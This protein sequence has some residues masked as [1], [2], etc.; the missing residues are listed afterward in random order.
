MPKLKA[1]TTDE[2]KDLIDRAQ[3]VQGDA[4]GIAHRLETN[5][6]TEIES[7]GRCAAAAL[8]VS[9]AFTELASVLMA[10]TAL[11]EQKREIDKMMRARA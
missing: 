4:A 10:R 9:R 7:P 6:S 8:A 5:F 2:L 11:D 1:V 3:D